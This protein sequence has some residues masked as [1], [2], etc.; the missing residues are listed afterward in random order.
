MICLVSVSL[1][2]VSLQMN[3]TLF[4][5]TPLTNLGETMVLPPPTPHQ[6]PKHPLVC[7]PNITY[8]YILPRLPEP[9]PCGQLSL[10]GLSHPFSFTLSP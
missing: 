6:V 8:T 5:Q 1:S 4:P 7:P 10:V 9:R 2:K 3:R